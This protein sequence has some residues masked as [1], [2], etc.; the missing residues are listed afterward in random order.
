MQPCI[1]IPLSLNFLPEASTRTSDVLRA[2]TITPVESTSA[3]CEKP[4]IRTAQYS[5]RDAETYS[6]EVVLE[7]ELKGL[8]DGCVRG[9]CDDRLESNTRRLH[10]AFLQHSKRSRILYTTPHMH[11]CCV[12]S[13]MHV[14]TWANHLTTADCVISLVILPVSRLSTGTRWTLW[15]P[16]MDRTCK[17]GC[18]V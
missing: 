10:R 18:D 7:H 17:G 1:N 12:G 4:S 15:R 3:T 8:D 11:E 14:R 5:R 2:V 13:Q 16:R 9:G 6:V